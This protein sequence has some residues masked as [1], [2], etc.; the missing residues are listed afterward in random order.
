MVM[1]D[2][3]PDYMKI[4]SNQKEVLLLASPGIQASVT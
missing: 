2:D 3:L 4:M 1:K